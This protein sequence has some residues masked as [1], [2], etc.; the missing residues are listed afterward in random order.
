MAQHDSNGIALWPNPV[1]EELSMVL[2]ADAGDLRITMV[3]ADGRVVRMVSTAYSTQVMV[4]VQD[5]AA[6]PYTVLVASDRVQWSAR[7]VK[8]P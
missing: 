6:G 2:P 7:F 1:K 8:V 3:A 4:P 5:L